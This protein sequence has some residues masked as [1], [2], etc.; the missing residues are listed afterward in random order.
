MK[1]ERI[2]SDARVWT[3]NRGTDGRLQHSV[4]PALVASLYP[5]LSDEEIAVIAAGTAEIAETRVW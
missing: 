1:F 5:G 3:V 2:D 4:D